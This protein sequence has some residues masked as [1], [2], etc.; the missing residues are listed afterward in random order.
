MVGRVQGR[1]SATIALHRPSTVKG[2]GR[3]PRLKGGGASGTPGAAPLPRCGVDTLM[4][5][6]LGET[7]EIRKLTRR[8]VLGAGLAAAATTLRRGP[9]RAAPAKR[10]KAR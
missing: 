2:S 3:R 6:G 1:S 10:R 7:P 8:T 5:M 9:A 4:V